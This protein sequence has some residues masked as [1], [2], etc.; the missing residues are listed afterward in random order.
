MTLTNKDIMLWL[1]AT[2]KI[3]NFK[4]SK[5]VFTNKLKTHSLRKVDKNT[6]ICEL[7]ENSY[8]D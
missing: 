2:V 7:K 3:L 8:G 4:I 5:T 1:L 6:Y